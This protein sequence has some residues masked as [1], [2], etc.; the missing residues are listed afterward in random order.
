MEERKPNAEFDPVWYRAYYADA[1]EDGG[2]PLVH[3]ILFGSKENR[4]QNEEEKYENEQLAKNSLEENATGEQTALNEH[5]NKAKSNSSFNL[6]MLIREHRNFFNEEFCQYNLGV[7]LDDNNIDD[8]YEEF[9]HKHGRYPR[10]SLYFDPDYYLSAYPDIAKTET[11]PLS[12]FLNTGFREYRNPNPLIDIEYI[13]NEETIGDSIEA[14]I[15]YL[16]KNKAPSAYFDAEF[17]LSAYKDVED[18][19]MLSF[20]HFVMDGANEKRKPNRFFDYDKYRE[21]RGLDNIDGLD[22]VIDFA[23]YGDRNMVPFSDEFDYAYYKNQVQVVWDGNVPLYKHFVSYGIENN[24]QPKK[25]VDFDEINAYASEELYNSLKD[26]LNIKKNINHRAPKLFEIDE[27]RAVETIRGLSFPKIPNPEISI[28]IP[29]YN[30]IKELAECL[31]SI[32]EFV[33]GN[34]EVVIADDKSPDENVEKALKG[35]ESIVYNRNTENLGFLLNVNKAIAVAKGEYVLLLNSDVQL[36][37]DIVATLKKELLADN[38]VGIA[39]P[40][41]IFPNGMLQEAGCT[42]YKNCE[43]KMIGIDQDAEDPA[44]NFK[45]YVDYIS[46]AA[47]L[48]RKSLFDSLGGFDKQLAPAYAED[49]DFCA[50]VTRNGK[51]ILYVPETTIVHHLSVSSNLMSSS[52]KYYQSAINKATFNKKYQTFYKEY[53]KIKPIA[54]YLP[55]YHDIKQNSYW[56]GKNYTEWQAAAGASPCFKGHY[57]PHVPSDMGFYN[58]LDQKSFENQANLARR[59][60]IY[61][62]CFYYY[63]FGDFELMEKALDTFLASKADINFCLCWANENW[64]RRWDGLETDVLLEQKGNNNDFFL[65]VL[66]GMERFIIDSRYIKVNDKPLVLI[67]RESLFEGI[68]VKLQIWRDYW[69]ETHNNEELYICVVDS[70]E[71]AGGQG[72]DSLPLGF[73]AAVEFPAH[74][75]EART[76]LKE[77]DI[78]DDKEEFEGI[79]IDYPDAVKEVCS[80]KHPGYKRFPGCFPAWDN[81]P[82][83]GN[84]AVVMHHAHPTAF[85]LFLEE[86]AK[87]ALLLHGDERM[88]FINAWNEWG[89]GTH[90]EPDVK[91]GHS[92]LRA[93]EKMVKDY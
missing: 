76:T 64:T 2:Y 57:Q 11:E 23:L 55:Q 10:I 22:L 24:I 81:T 85:Q 1:K 70:M 16:E 9:V 17:Y 45:R 69:R 61:G 48:F 84:K 35:H 15:R 12:H 50:R 60:G 87:E 86:K 36:L 74:N 47:W 8:K 71:R 80:R 56:W 19:G 25:Q 49:L 29:V 30:A 6:I 44:Y 5:S 53:S 33:V 72:K 75:I 63:N 68:E 26:K 59:Y 66:H 77:E 93:V 91:Y 14:L 88:I 92:A 67:Y 18:A 89:E 46:G 13:D 7:S 52:F 34:F 27:N 62:F 38:Q 41:I 65:K 51:K 20:E 43:T 78:L 39:G 21:E 40:K 37:D 73:D 3:Y 28:V 31:L 90:L 32:E 42:I 4:F 82:R 58:L 54:F 83:R 79:L